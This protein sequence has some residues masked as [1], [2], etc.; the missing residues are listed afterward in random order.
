[1]AAGAR[2]SLI[3]IQ[4][5]LASQEENLLNYLLIFTV[6]LPGGI[7]GR[8]IYDSPLSG[9]YNSVMKGSV[10]VVNTLLSIGAVM[11]WNR[12]RLGQLKAEPNKPVDRTR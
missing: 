9:D 8:L 5:F 1:M 2:V 12:K 11:I 7:V 10:L 6:L 3:A 4:H